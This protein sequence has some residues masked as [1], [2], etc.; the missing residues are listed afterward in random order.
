MG[1]I[2]FRSSSRTR[3]GTARSRLRLRSSWTTTGLH[4]LRR[5]MATAEDDGSNV[6]ALTW[7][8][9]A[10][11]PAPVARAMVQL[12]QATCGA[13]KSVDASGAA[14]VTA[15][16]PGNYSVR[17]WLIDVPWSRR[18][19]QRRGRHGEGAFAGYRFVDGADEG[20]GG[21]DGASVARQRHDCAQRAGAGELAVEGAWADRRAWVAPRDDPRQQDRADVQSVSSCSQPGGDDSHRDPG[22]GS[23][24]RSDTR[25]PRLSRGHSAPARHEARDSH[26]HLGA[27]RDD[28]VSR[29]AV[30][31][32]HTRAATSCGRAARPRRPRC[33]RP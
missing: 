24:R 20:R 32:R 30:G 16:G 2:R 10:N 1:G 5:S 9:P 17:L 28:S 27:C 23:D 19:A 31:D 4:R 8:D 29:A 15:P 33:G 21:R 6:V 22:R 26:R 18:A 11:P 25:P 12:C 7:R 13:A 3:L 14:R